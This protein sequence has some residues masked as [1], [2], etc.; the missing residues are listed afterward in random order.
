[1]SIRRL[2]GSHSALCVGTRLTRGDCSRPGLNP[3][4]QSPLHCSHTSGARASTIYRCANRSHSFFS[5]LPVTFTSSCSLV[6]FAE[7]T[8]F[9]GCVGDW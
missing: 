9:V 3:A 1:M 7:E 6:C 2:L 5:D 8:S 4:I